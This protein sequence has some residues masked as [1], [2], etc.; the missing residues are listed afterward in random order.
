MPKMSGFTLGNRLRSGCRILPEPF[1][2]EL[3][4]PRGLLK[5]LTDGGSVPIPVS[6]VP[7]L[8]EI[9]NWEHFMCSR[10][11]RDESLGEL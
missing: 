5:G 11:C 2:T 8:A 1:L 9:N 10:T 4:V 7:V 6:C 3:I